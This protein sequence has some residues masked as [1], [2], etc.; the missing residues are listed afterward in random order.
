MPLVRHASSARAVRP[1]SVKKRMD[2]SEVILGPRS[3]KLTAQ[4][5]VIR[6]LGA[7]FEKTVPVLTNVF[8]CFEC[9]LARY[10]MRVAML[11]F[12]LIS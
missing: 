10:A 9:S 3:P 7:I 1:F 4:E 11:L 12:S 5:V 6:F 8:A 2:R